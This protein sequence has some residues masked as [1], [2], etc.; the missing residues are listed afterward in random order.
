VI[1][2]AL[3]YLPESISID[4]LRGL[5]WERTE[6]D[7][8]VTSVIEFKERIVDEGLEAWTG[9][10]YHQYAAS[11]ASLVEEGGHYKVEFHNVPKT[12]SADIIVAS[13]RLPS[14]MSDPFIIVDNLD[15]RYF[16]TE[17]VKK[18]LDLPPNTVNEVRLNTSRL[19]GLH[20]E[21]WV[22]GF[23]DRAG[24]VDRGVVFG[25]GIEQDDVFGPEFE[26]STSQLVGWTTTFFGPP[27]K[28]RVSPRGSVLVWSWPSADQFLRFIVREIIPHVVL[29][30]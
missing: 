11:E 14:G 29:I 24:R 20:T 6:S 21:Q 15:N 1:S 9:I 23:T 28:V 16:V 13:A 4:A 10:A 30:Q 18:G 5:K 17:I 3:I 27:T 2:G 25:E 12:L 22:R 8:Q 19:A 26:R 7:I